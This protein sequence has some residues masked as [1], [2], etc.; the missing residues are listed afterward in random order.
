MQPLRPI[1]KIRSP[2]LVQ[3]HN[4]AVDNSVGGKINE[5]LPDLRESC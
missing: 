5:R 2:G 4:F 3:G 1:P